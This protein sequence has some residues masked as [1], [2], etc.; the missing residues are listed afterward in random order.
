MR[1]REFITLIGDVAAA[2]STRAQAR[3]RA[4]TIGW[5]FVG[6]ELSGRRCQPL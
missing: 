6:S 2:W 3:Q 4:M 5:L 1:R